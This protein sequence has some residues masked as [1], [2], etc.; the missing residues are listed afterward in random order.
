MGTLPADLRKENQR[1][2]MK[3]LLRN[4]DATIIEIAEKLN[5]SRLTVKKC[6]DY[7]IEKGIV[8]TKGK[9]D[10]TETGGKKPLLYGF[11]EDRFMV[12]VQLHRDAVILSLTNMDNA[13]LASWENSTEEISS[14]DSFWRITEKLISTH[15]NEDMLKNILICCLVVPLIVDE[16]HRLTIATPF[17]K[18]PQSDLGKNI[19]EPFENLFP[20][21]ILCDVISDCCASGAA[22]IKQ[23][24][25]LEKT[26]TLV[27]FYINQGIGGAIFQNGETDN[28]FGR[29]FGHIVVCEDDDER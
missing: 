21:V 22:L 14:L 9:G 3:Y 20:N 13:I 15:L 29:A 4:G 5:V 19:T 16:K 25:E 23:Q 17:E 18:W 24:E 10:S 12:C 1:K 8:V 28:K 7:Y 26:S 2:V 11:V 6:L 27:T